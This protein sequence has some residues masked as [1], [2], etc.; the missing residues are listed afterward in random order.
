MS[1]STL[2][3]KFISENNNWE[4]ILSN[5]PYCLKI[6][7]DEGFIIFNYNQIDSDFSN[8]IVQEAR[9]IIFKEEQWEYPVCHA[10]DKF[11][12]YGETNCANVNFNKCW[13]TEKVDGSIIKLWYNWDKNCWQVSTNG[14]IDAYKAMYDQ[15]R[16]KTFGQLVE[17]TVQKISGFST[18]DEFMDESVYSRNLTYIFELVSPETRVVIPYEENNLYYLGCRDNIRNSELPFYYGCCKFNTNGVKL[19]KIYPMGNFEEILKASQEL[20]WDKEGYVVVDEEC[21]RCKIKSPAYVLAHYGRS[22]NSLT[23]EKL[24][25]VITS[26]VEDDFLVYA[27]DYKE[28]LQKIKEQMN[29]YKQDCKNAWLSLVNE[30]FETKKDFALSVQ[31]L[32]KYVW[33]Y[34]F[35]CYDKYVSIEDYVMNWDANKW[36]KVLDSMED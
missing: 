25:D 10:F 26:G 32:K 6:K 20:P 22:N 9:G 29:Q 7:R 13:V 31:K 17:E 5:K 14:M 12:N 24:V 34:C 2:I 1:Y 4:E 19:P 35:S 15:V 27:E 11:F 23:K 33:A 36:S 18:V 3:G 16:N 8:P 30:P 28:P 21:N